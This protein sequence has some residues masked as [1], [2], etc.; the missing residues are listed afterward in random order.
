M[1]SGLTASTVTM[2]TGHNT[3]SHQ[4]T[5]TTT[6]AHPV[7][8]SVRRNQASRSSSQRP[9]RRMHCSY[10]CT[11][12]CSPG[13]RDQQG[14]SQCSCLP[15]SPGGTCT[16]RWPGRSDRWRSRTFLR[17]SGQRYL[18]DRL[19][20]TEEL[21]MMKWCLMSSDVGWDIRDKLWPMPKH[22]SINLYVHGSQKAC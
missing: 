11:S 3:H 5:T 2:T 6:C 9:G 18:L 19:K 22:G 15:S 12:A 17:S 4:A 13:Q 1:K 10:T 16:C 8:T 14:T 7:H 21:L 20:Y